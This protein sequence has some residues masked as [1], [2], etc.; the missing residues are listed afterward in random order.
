M[1]R[2]YEAGRRAALD[3]NPGWRTLMPIRWHISRWWSIN[4]PTVVTL[5]ALGLAIV[6]AAGMGA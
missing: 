3:H 4:W 5:L 1:R 2:S 6:V